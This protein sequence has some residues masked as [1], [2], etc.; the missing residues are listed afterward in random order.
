[1]FTLCLP[2]RP[3]PCVCMFTLIIITTFDRDQEWDSSRSNGSAGLGLKPVL[4]GVLRR[5]GPVG[6]VREKGRERERREWGAGA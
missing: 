4:G 2:A 5:E 1:M 6:G 3:R